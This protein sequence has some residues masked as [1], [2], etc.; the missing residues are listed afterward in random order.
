M[1]AFISHFQL[2][3]TASEYFQ[4][5]A[6]KHICHT[7]RWQLVLAQTKHNRYP[8][9]PNENKARQI[10]HQ[11]YLYSTATSSIFLRISQHVRQ[12]LQ[13]DYPTPQKRVEKKQQMPPCLELKTY[14]LS[15][16]LFSSIR[17]RVFCASI[18]QWKEDS[19]WNG[20]ITSKDSLIT[21]ASGVSHTIFYI[22]TSWGDRCWVPFLCK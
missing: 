18:F 11:N 6:Y 9:N 17:H 14:I 20:P 16:V 8:L 4:N 19:E 5:K 12:C 7:I 1:N 22:P 2:C 10:T 15:I 13:F 3:D 21:N